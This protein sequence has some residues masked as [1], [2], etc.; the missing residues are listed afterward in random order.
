MLTRQRSGIFLTV[1]ASRCLLHSFS[2]LYEGGADSDRG[3]GG[4][5]RLGLKATMRLGTP[6]QAVATSLTPAC[7]Q[8]EVVTSTMASTMSEWGSQL[9]SE[10][11][12]LTTYLPCSP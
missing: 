7:D 5:E 9:T 4:G 10:Q 8:R 2:S 11:E 3:R 12:R 6:V 1:A